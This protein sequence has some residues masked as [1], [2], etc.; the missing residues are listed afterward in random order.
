MALGFPVV[1]V[2]A[3]AGGISALSSLFKA[4]PSK[5]GLAFVV[6]Q[7]L[8]PTHVSR[9]VHLLSDATRLTLLEAVDGT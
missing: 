4:M 9:L 3:S 6:V 8:S 5:P 1:G 2:G 7:H